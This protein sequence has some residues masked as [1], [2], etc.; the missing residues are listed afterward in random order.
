MKFSK[1]LIALT[2]ASASAFAFG[3]ET[4]SKTQTDPNSAISGH[5]GLVTISSKGYDVRDVLFD[6]FV[7][8]KKSFVLDPEVRYLL[9]LSLQDIDFD[10]ALAV[11]CEEAKLSFTLENGIYYLAKR[12]EQPVKVVQAQEIAVHKP[13]KLEDSELLKHLTTRLKMTDIR[14]VFGEFSR[15]TGIKIEVSK[16]VPNYK[17][18]AYLID[19][20]LKYALDVV[21]NAAGLK[22]TKTDDRSI[23]IETK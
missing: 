14:A 1:A 23:L 16:S 22:Y 2:I 15:Q 8:G 3:Q 18:D 10:E 7:K 5:D 4:G 6:L 13:G 21:T 12:K 11:V 9:Y 20:S 19:T 17:L